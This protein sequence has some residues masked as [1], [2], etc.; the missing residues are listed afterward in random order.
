MYSLKIQFF[1]VNE[2]VK[3]MYATNYIRDALSPHQAPLV[4]LGDSSI[5]RVELYSGVPC[6]LQQLIS[7]KHDLRMLL[8][9][10]MVI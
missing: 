3:Y 7:D 10:C 9:A 4:Y 5:H 8:Y 2:K 6:L 1:N